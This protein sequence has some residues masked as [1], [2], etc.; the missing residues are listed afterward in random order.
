MAELLIKMQD[1]T[2]LDSGK[3]RLCYKRGDVVEVR[4]DNAKYGN[5]ECFFKSDE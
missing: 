3:D 1:N 2:N 5:K 4:E